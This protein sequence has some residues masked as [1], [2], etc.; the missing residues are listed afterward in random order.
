[1]AA[2]IEQSSAAN[3]ARVREVAG[4]L[5]GTRAGIEAELQGKLKEMGAEV[6]KAA[7]VAAEAQKQ[8]EVAAAGAR[9][10]AVRQMQ[11]SKKEVVEGLERRM[12]VALDAALET[13]KG[14]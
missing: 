13:I 4:K 1:M 14:G 6:E 12:H 5:E 3:D 8:A 10:E 2:A 11:E 7:A 9:E